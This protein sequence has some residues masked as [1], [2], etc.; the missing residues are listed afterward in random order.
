MAQT[1]DD[2]RTFA[3]GEVGNVVSNVTS[4][5]YSPDGGSF[6]SGNN[7]GLIVVR[8]LVNNNGFK[9]ILKEHTGEI[10][11]L[12]YHPDQR[13]MAS[14]ATDGKL[15]VWDLN[16]SK[17][18][19]EDIAPAGQH[20][21]FCFF[22]TDRQTIMYGGTGGQL[23]VARPF[24]NPSKSVVLTTTAL[25]CADYKPMY[26]GKLIM[27]SSGQLKVADFMSK[28]VEKE[29]TVCNGNIVSTKYN[30]NG[31]QV[32]CLCSDGN[33]SFWSLN[34]GQKLKEVNVGT[35]TG[36]STQL[37][38][39][40]DGNYLVVGNFGIQPLVYDLNTMDII[41]Q[42]RSH[43]KNVR[44]VNFG[45]DSKNILTGGDD[46]MVKI[47]KWRNILPNEVLPTPPPPTATVVAP[48]PPAK[49]VAMALVEPPK[50]DKKPYKPLPELT[51]EAPKPKATAPI[52]KLPDEDDTYVE[53]KNFPLKSVKMELGQ[54][55]RRNRLPNAMCARVRPS[56][57]TIWTS[58]FA[59]GIG[60]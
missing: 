55:A 56:K 23:I 16:T 53:P 4:V 28:K 36:K 9:N 12:A 50:E 37:A 1:F 51:L 39:S 6:A 25:T 41:A 31:S 38:F 32:A 40:P 44:T 33:L 13:Y 27:A 3:S 46:N 60:I 52:V 22:T 59:F 15:K 19:Y 42:L 5:K 18:I 29:W 8:D 30:A 54:P 49:T 21:T 20:F 34:G 14:T 24:N 11:D 2:Y 35:F 47:S 43:L 48:P 58:P 17:V 7:K 10:T 57:F 45:P 26:N